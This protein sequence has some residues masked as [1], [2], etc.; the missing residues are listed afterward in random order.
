MVQ[1][2]KAGRTEKGNDQDY[3]CCRCLFSDPVMV[4]GIYTSSRARPYVA[5]NARPREGEPATPASDVDEKEVMSVVIDFSKRLSH[6]TRA[7]PRLM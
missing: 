6:R 4:G 1:H 3:C 7:K 2:T 5:R